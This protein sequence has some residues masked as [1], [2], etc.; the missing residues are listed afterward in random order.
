MRE[1]EGEELVISVNSLGASSHFLLTFLEGPAPEV[2]QLGKNS[3]LDE[4]Q[5]SLYLP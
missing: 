4:E 3:C 1:R 2:P 5:A